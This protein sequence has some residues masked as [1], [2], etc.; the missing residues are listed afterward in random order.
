MQIENGTYRL[1]YHQSIRFAVDSKFRV[2]K[3][4]NIHT[5]IEHITKLNNHVVTIM[6]IN[7]N[8]EFHQISLFDTKKHSASELNVTV[9]EKEI[10]R[11]ISKGLSSDKIADIL[12]IKIGRAHV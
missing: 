8:T 3:S 10:I 11:Y 1:F 4:L 5:Y 12:G 7:G 2:V 9:R 6:G